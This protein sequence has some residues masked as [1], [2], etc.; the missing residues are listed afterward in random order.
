MPQPQ[1]ETLRILR[2]ASFKTVPWK[3][4]G[5]VTHE[6]IRVHGLRAADLERERYSADAWNRA[7]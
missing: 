4:G 7:R 1:V 5:G 3:N 6:A 2:R